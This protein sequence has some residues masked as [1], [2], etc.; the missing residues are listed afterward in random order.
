MSCKAIDI[1][2]QLAYVR[3][4]IHCICNNIN[5]AEIERAA[6]HG[7]ETADCVQRACGTEFNC[8]QCRAGINAQ[9]QA[10]RRKNEC[11]LETEFTMAAE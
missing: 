5:S 4:M 7:A 6:A 10:W 1:H 8:G 11:T 3:V 9:I 2:S